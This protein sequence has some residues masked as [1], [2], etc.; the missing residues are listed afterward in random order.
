[1][2]QMLFLGAL[3]M[4]SLALTLAVAAAPLHSRAATWTAALLTPALGYTIWRMVG[5]IAPLGVTLDSRDPVEAF[6]LWM[7]GAACL[8]GLAIVACMVRLA[9]LALE[10]RPGLR[11]ATDT[12]A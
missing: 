8:F 4:V 9:R 10:A 12:D 6:D 3:G 5:F 7:T 1:M 2:S 11:M